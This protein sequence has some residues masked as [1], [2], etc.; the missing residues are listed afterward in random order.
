MASLTAGE[1]RYREFERLDD[2]GNPTSQ[3]NVAKYVSDADEHIRICF[4]HAPVHQVESGSV[5]QMQF[6]EVPNKG[7]SI[8]SNESVRC[9]VNLN[10]PGLV[11]LIKCVCVHDEA[12]NHDFNTKDKECFLCRSIHF[13]IRFYFKNVYF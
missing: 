6:E 3:D 11:H 1:G 5:E 8:V 7:P 13:M 10:D 4:D 9:L 12:Q 2:T